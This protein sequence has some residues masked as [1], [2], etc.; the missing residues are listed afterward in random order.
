[1]TQLINVED[2]KKDQIL[3]E[4]ADRHTPIVLSHRLDAGWV[5]YKSQFLQADSAGH[6]LII[7]QPLAEPGQAPPELVPGDKI[8]IS[9]RRGHKKC[10]CS[11]EVER[12]L[13]FDA[14]E[15]VMIPALQIPWPIKLQEMQ[16][17]VYYRAQVPSGRRI[18][19]HLWDGCINDLS[20][21]DLKNRP[22]HIGL[23][24]DLSAGG[25]RVIFDVS[26]DPCLEVGD[27]VAIQF[28]PD[29]RTTPIALEAM[30][31]HS[32]PLPQ[33]KLALGFQFVGLELTPEGRRLLQNLS[34]VVSA[35]MRI[36]LRR[37]NLRKA[38]GHNPRRR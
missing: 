38:P 20:P 7:T 18:E 24:M 22:H 21:A 35:F 32:E 25:C 28:Q 12:L 36:D 27:T 23:L 34:R 16:R 19:V 15:S 13:T 11:V 8:G 10:M 14:G 3:T 6:F 4:A 2:E 9:F 17:R 30:Y 29:P 1:M 5:T 26:R 33:S 37:N 31:R